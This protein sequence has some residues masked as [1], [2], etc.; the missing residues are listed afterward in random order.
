[1]IKVC[2]I[3]HGDIGKA[4]EVS[5]NQHNI[6]DLYIYDKKAGVLDD[7]KLSSADIIFIC[8]PT[9]A[10]SEVLN[11]I[12][13]YR[14]P[15]S[16]AVALSKGIDK[17]TGK[18]VHELMTDFLPSNDFAILAGPMLAQEISNGMGGVGVLASK[19]HEAY[20]I[21]NKIFN[22]KILS[23]KYSDDLAGIALFSILKNI[24]TLA[25]GIV[26]GLSYGKNIQGWITARSF[27]EW[28][29]IADKLGIKFNQDTANLILSDFVATS[30][31]PLSQ[32]RTAGIQIAE[33]KKPH[34]SEGLNAL[35]LL[36]K[37]LNYDLSGLPILEAMSK[38]ILQKADPRLAIDKIL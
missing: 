26:T 16:F 35:S 4:I 34:P 20:Q 12:N 23:V 6:G 5:L 38:I 2:I 25:I 22:N 21:I 7:H 14:K 37:R 8:T 15:E 29:I 27:S 18:L 17:T 9:S 19:N 30:S 32:N 31:S 28:P 33:G 24:Y 1:M 36:I 10:L 3:G 11:L 13:I